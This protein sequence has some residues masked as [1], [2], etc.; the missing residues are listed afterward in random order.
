[1]R[2][3]ICLQLPNARQGYWQVVKDVNAV[4]KIPIRT[5]TIGALLLFLLVFPQSG[6]VDRSMISMSLLPLSKGHY[7]FATSYFALML[8]SPFLNVFIRSASRSQLLA[9]IGTLLGIY[10]LLPSFFDIYLTLSLI[11]I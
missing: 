11:P 6:L 3:V 9:A 2:L 8:F 1:M 5:L 10:V 7:W 4:E